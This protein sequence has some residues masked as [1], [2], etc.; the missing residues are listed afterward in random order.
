[1]MGFPQDIGNNKDY[2]DLHFRYNIF[3][4]I[5]QTS[6]INES[7]SLKKCPFLTLQS[8]VVLH[9]NSGQEIRLL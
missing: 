4:Y 3:Q 6:V 7:S 2:S 9:R 8:R 5:D 1:M